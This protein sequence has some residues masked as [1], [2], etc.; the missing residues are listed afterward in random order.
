VGRAA[1]RQSERPPIDRPLGMPRQSHASG[2]R[3]HRAAVQPSLDYAGR[4]NVP[5]SGLVVLLA[6]EGF[7]LLLAARIPKVWRGELSPRM[8][9]NLGAAGYEGAKNQLAV[10]AI[11][12][13]AVGGSVFA[14]TLIALAFVPKGAGAYVVLGL[15]L[16]AAAVMIGLVTTIALFNRPACLIPPIA[17]S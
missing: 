17:R 12:V 4:V 3:H 14:A 10:R 9:A 5:V 16:V 7:F 2:Q 8:Q 13:V 15:A 1:R 11:A 6:L